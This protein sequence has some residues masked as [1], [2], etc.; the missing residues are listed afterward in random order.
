MACPRNTF[1]S[2][3]GKKDLVS[4]IA[5]EDDLETPEP[6]DG[7]GATRC[8]SEF[9]WISNISEKFTFFNKR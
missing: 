5:C 6:V 9:S 8:G 7:V 3:V 2:E 1:N 4:C